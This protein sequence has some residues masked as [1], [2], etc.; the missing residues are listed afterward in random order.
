MVLIGKGGARKSQSIGDA[1][2]ENGESWMERERRERE[3][4]RE[5]LC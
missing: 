1:R 5:R 2:G 4:E 3:R